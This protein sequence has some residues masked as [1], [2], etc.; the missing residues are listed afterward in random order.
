LQCA[1]R[2]PVV[3][4]CHLRQKRLQVT[5]TYPCCDT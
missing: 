1:R 5:Q 2:H 4:M 3:L